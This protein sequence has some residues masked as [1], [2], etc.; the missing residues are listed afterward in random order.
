MKQFIEKLR[1]LKFGK[2][3]LLKNKWKYAFTVTSFPYYLHMLN[4]K[5]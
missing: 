1:M 4:R 2:K 3:Y 5:M